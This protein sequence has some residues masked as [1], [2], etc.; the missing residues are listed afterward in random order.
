MTETEHNFG[1]FLFLGVVFFLFFFLDI[2]RKSDFKICKLQINFKA[3]QLS[4][5]AKSCTIKAIV[6][7]LLIVVITTFLEGVTCKN[8][9][10]LQLK[11]SGSFEVSANACSQVCVPENTWVYAGSDIWMI[12]LISSFCLG[13]S[14]H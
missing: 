7:F 5:I 1:G 14:T 13:H 3:G 9:Q 4:E 6:A 8:K 12:T 10:T 11:I 2:L